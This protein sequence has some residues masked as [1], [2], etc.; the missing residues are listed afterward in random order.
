MVHMEFKILRESLLFKILLRGAV[1]KVI[2]KL[3]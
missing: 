3:D 1:E 2:F